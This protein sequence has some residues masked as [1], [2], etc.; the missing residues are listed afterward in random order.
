[1]NNLIPEEWSYESIES[2]SAKHKGAIKIGPF[3]SALSKKEMVSAGVKVYGQENVYKNDFRIGNYFITNEK[4]QKLKTCTL[5]KGDVVITMMGTVG[6]STVVPNDAEIGVMDSHLLRIQVDCLRM[7]RSLLSLLL[8]DSQDVKDQIRKMSQGGIMSGLNAA[9]VKSIKVPVPPIIEQQKIARILTSANEMIEKTQAQIDKL[10]DLKKGILQELL[11]QGIGHTQY[12]NSLVGRIPTEWEVTKFGDIT[13]EHKQGF[14]SKDKYTS[15][16]TYLIRI[17]DMKNPYISFTKMPKMIISDKD[18]D[19]YRV[20]NGDFLFARSG[21]IGRY[22]I[23]NSNNEAIFASYLI[24]F[25]FNQN[26]ALN[27]FIGFWYESDICQKQLRTITQGSSNINI[28]AQ[29]IKELLIPLPSI[30]EQRK[31]TDVILSVVEKISSNE[32]KLTSYENT[33]KALMQDLL[34]GKVRVKTELT[35]TEVAMG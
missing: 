12:K 32:R 20:V 23:F 28:N 17:T 29:N 21:A 8:R 19:A 13:I 14:Y 22:G 33:K 34:T 16:G 11:T 10:K 18:K 25:R 3:G 5:N 35:N 15:D 2:I 6:S 7:D 24:R 9:I 26:K 1:M 27:E 4:Y 31:V 30:N